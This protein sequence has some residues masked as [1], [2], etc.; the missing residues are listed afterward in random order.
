MPSKRAKKRKKQQEWEQGTVETRSGITLATKE[1]GGYEIL[2][3]IPDSCEGCGACCREQESPPMYLYALTQPSHFREKC[4]DFHRAHNLPQELKDELLEY[5]EGLSSGEP[6]PNAG[7]CIWFDR[8]TR[9]CKH[10][11]LRPSICRET[12]QVG[13]ESC[14]SWRNEYS[15]TIIGGK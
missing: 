4:E 2:A 6:H 7:A 5:G 3:A 15:D 14:L 10:Y 13:D 12:V 1:Q 8:R 11:D 9:K